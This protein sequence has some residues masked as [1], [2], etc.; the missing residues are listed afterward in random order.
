MGTRSLFTT[1]LLVAIALLVFG[2]DQTVRAGTT[3][4]PVPYTDDFANNSATTDDNGT[5]FWTTVPN[6]LFTPNQVT[7]AGS[8]LIMASDATIGA[9]LV[10]IDVSST[11]NFFANPL[12]FSVSGLNMS[13]ST[14][15]ASAQLFRFAVQDSGSVTAAAD[16]TSP[17]SSGANGAVVID[18]TGANHLTL[19]L[20]E[21]GLSVAN[22][23]L[24][25]DLLGTPTGFTL[26]LNG[27]ATTPTFSL[28]VNEG[29]SSQTFNG[30]LT[31]LNQTNWGANGEKGWSAISLAALNNNGGTGTLV[32]ATVD[33]VSVIAIPE[34]G[35]LALLTI[36]T[37][38]GA[39]RIKRR[40]H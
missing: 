27:T 10:G 28:L 24:S 39:I 35:T 3:Y 8:N 15:P 36:G 5:T 29:S 1:R 18:I 32:T 7:E 21:L 4:P 25:V 30:A 11:F 40:R 20:K 22:P 16:A 17:L 34:P 31:G 33:S 19:N 6:S 26:T 38:L 12:A 2:A 9:T 37:L 13:L 14:A 23:L